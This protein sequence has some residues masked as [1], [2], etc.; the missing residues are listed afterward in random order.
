MGPIS[1]IAL[2]QSP[3]HLS[4]LLVSLAVVVAVAALGGFVSADA[5]ADYDKLAQPSWGPPNYLIG[6]IWGVLYLMMAL[7]AWLVW[8]ADPRWRSPAIIAYGVQLALNLVWSALFFGLGWRGLALLD[9][10]LLDVAVAITIAAFWKVRRAA[11]FLMM[12]YLA[13]I[14][15]ATVLNYY[16]WSMNS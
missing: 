16:V 7:A 5:A 4:A 12:P 10:L 6:P 13:W 14:L 3:Q 9:V 11:A 8:R 2:R 15:I 1:T